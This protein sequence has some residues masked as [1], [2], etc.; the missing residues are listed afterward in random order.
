MY[1]LQFAETNHKNTNLSKSRQTNH[2]LNKSILFFFKNSIKII[3][4]YINLFYF[5]L[6]ITHKNTVKHPKN[7]VLGIGDFTLIKAEFAISVKSSVISVKTVFH[8][9][10]KIYVMISNVSPQTMG[11]IM[12]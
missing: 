1:Y 5:S 6:K 10:V 2:G 3:L 9:T 7:E 8:S 4:R 11:Y 12:D